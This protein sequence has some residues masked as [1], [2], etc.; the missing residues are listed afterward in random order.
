MD[1]FSAVAPPDKADRTPL[2]DALRA[3]LEAVTGVRS[4][5]PRVTITLEQA[6][7]DKV[8]TYYQRPYRPKPQREF[9]VSMDGGVV[10]FERAGEVEECEKCAR[11]AALVEESERRYREHA[12]GVCRDPGCIDA[13]A[14]TDAAGPRHGDGRLALH[15]LALGCAHGQLPQGSD[16]PVCGV[17]GVGGPS[18]LILSALAAGAAL[19]AAA[20]VRSLDVADATLGSSAPVTSTAADFGVVYG[21]PW[22]APEDR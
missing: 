20:D 4:D 5:K 9:C 21:G 1:A 17:K 22:V 15:D 19:K 16:C 14:T 2:D 11:E 3:L 10:W 13:T 6:E 12:A 8:R 7:W 18:P